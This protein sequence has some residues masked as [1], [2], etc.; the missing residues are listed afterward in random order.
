MPNASPTFCASAIIAAASV[1][2][3]GK[4]QM[5]S[6]VARVSALIGLKVRLPQSFIQISVRTSLSTG[7]LKPAREKSS[8]S[9][10][11]RAL[12]EPSISASGRRLPSTWRMTPG[13][14]ISA[15]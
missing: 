10:A 4:R 1:R 3:G 14:S 15:A 11:T 9:A 12:F 13:L 7:D 6:S 2:V 5:S 8:A